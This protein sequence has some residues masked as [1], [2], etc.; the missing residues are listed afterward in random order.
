MIAPDI[1]PGERDA[2]SFLTF[3]LLTALAIFVVTL[4]AGW[5]P[6]IKRINTGRGID[7]P[8]GEALASGVFLG[9]GLLHMLSDASKGFGASG[10]DYPFAPLLAGAM[11]LFLLW[12]EHLGRD[13]YQH[14][15]EH[16]DSA[17]QCHHHT[18]GGKSF[19]L[20]ALGMLSLH[21]FLESAA[22]GL[23]TNFTIV[24]M[25]AIA[26]LAHKW[27]ESFALAIQFTKSSLSSKMGLLYFL[28]FALVAPLGIFLGGFASDKIQ[29][30]PLLGPTFL[31][32]AAGTFLYLGTLHGLSRAVMVQQCCNLKQY[33]F[34][35]IGFSLMAIVAIWT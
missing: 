19:A 32:L 16:H 34:V 6:F 14:E 8:I 17:K 1:T 11:F 4:S 10:Y 5:M 3:K 24:L 29:H 28:L 31:A 23:S 21:A 15:H 22:L 33:T 13:Y 18:H 25:L 26:I 20:L 9:V 27:A 2:M 30:L 12:L 35:I 7:F